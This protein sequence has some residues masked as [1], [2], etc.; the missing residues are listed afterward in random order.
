MVPETTPG[1]KLTAAGPLPR[2]GLS[3][4]FNL[5]NL[6][7]L[8]RLLSVPFAVW[9]IV[10]QRYAAAF[11]VFVA[12]G[13]SDGVDGYIAKN[14]NRRTRLGALLDPAADKLL[15]S[16][17]YLSLGY[18]GQLPLWLV[19]LVVLRDLLIVLGVGV[20]HMIAHAPKQF[21]PLYISK[22]NTFVQLALVVF[23][24]ARLGLEFEPG[25]FDTALTM[26]AAVTTV[27]SGASYLWR[28]A[29]ILCPSK[30]A[31]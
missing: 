6:I 27:L 22:V 2:A 20:I 29:R 28:W 12:A 23:V 16:G 18:V 9:L 17:V 14:F 1:P 21:G 10:Q 19:V 5:P 13:V 3:P 24:L 26:T 15:V 30:E 4:D 7:T 8:C 31:A 11:W 25:F